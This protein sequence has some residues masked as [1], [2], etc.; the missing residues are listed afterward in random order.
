MGKLLFTRF[1]LGTVPILASAKMGLSPSVPT[2]APAKMG[3]SRSVCRLLAVAIVLL[4]VSPPS[5]RATIAS[6]GDV[7]PW[8][9]SS[10]GT[11]TTSYIGNT[12]SGT[13]TV[14]GGNLLSYYGYVGYGGSAS[15]VV[16]VS[17]STS[18]WTNGGTVTIGY[19]GSGT[20]DITSGGSLSDAAGYLGWQ[21]GSKGAVTVSGVGSTWTNTYSLLVGRYGSATLSISGGGSVSNADGYIG[22][23]SGAKGIV[24]VDGAG[25]TWTSRGSLTIGVD[26]NY[27]NNGGTLAITNAG[28]VSVVGE[29]R[30]GAGRASTGTITFGPGSGTLTTQSFFASPSQLAGTGTVNARGLVTDID[31][32]FD[33]THALK[34][35]VTLEQ[36][37]QSITVNLDMSVGTANGALGAGWKGAG[38]LTV[39][40]GMTV[41][42]AC[43]Y[44]GYGTAS[45]AS[46]TVA[47][48]G[49][50]WVNSGDLCVGHYGSG[51]LLITGGGTVS[52]VHG[53]VGDASGA[54]GVVTVSGVGSAWT[55]AAS[56]D[57]GGYGS[58]TLS[59]TSGGSVSSSA[60][61]IANLGG[62]MSAV[63][64]DGAGSK[65][66]N[67]GGLSLGVPSNF[68]Y[69]T[70]TLSIT[71][72]GAV[73]NTSGYV[74]GGN[75]TTAMVRISDP[76]STWTNTSNLCVGYGYV[77]KGTVSQADGTVSVGGALFLASESTSQGMYNLT[78][79]V[80]ILN[81]LSQGSGTAAF[82]FG[83]GTLRA[84]AAF[85]S[86]VP[87]NLTG[88]DGDA[89]VDTAGFA[90][91]LSGTLSGPGGLTKSGNGTLTLS[92]ANKYTGVTTVNSGT[93]T[94]SVSN[95]IYTGGVTLTGGVFNLNGHT[96]SVGAVMLAGGTIAGGTL[97][98]TVGFG[99]SSGAVSAVLA[100]SVG[101]AKSGSGT[102]ILSAANTYTGTTSVGSG[103]LVFQGTA[104]INAALSKTVSNVSAGMLVFD[105]S[106]NTASGPSIAGQINSIL[107][108]SYNGGTNSW[109]SGRI[110]STLANT[111]STDGYALGWT[112]NTTT[113]AVTVKVVLYGDADLDG[114]V[115]IYDLGKI[116]ANYNQSGVWA[117]GDFNYDGTVNIYDLGKILANYNKSISLSGVSINAADYAGLDGQGLAALQAA[118][119]NVVPEP[120][121]LALLAAGA[122]G[123]GALMRRRRT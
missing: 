14:N 9:A 3:L 57:V 21:S 20:L 91:T 71:N 11:G 87:M 24:A 7:N 41:N 62:F 66:T 81:G 98:S 100:G 75:S 65:W 107:T 30:V 28:S 90:V 40:D 96:D 18:K 16:A 108:A 32:R 10:W 80:L 72:G 69:G 6:S 115:N 86:S 113:S 116:L 37:G 117:T 101:L 67:S 42:S 64:V 119:V 99:V 56:L 39:Q 105:Y 23:Y 27:Y 29:T 47:G 54:K 38:S 88:T 73:S 59:I 83:G 25:S 33:S 118:G 52:N 74:A 111:H 89:N 95:A 8:P 22:S 31:L 106:G 79:G 60:G 76:G 58:G 12:A 51:A 122:V 4:A 19:F 92:A 17:G 97:T 103:T 78:G 70:A 123:L 2:F 110:Y 48:T 85:S 109:A 36:S 77:D 68:C 55:N 49:S 5:A 121:T 15:G 94:E 84:G 53:I 43:G 63:S 61:Y 114:T 93:L 34:R 26:D 44:L 35:T 102:V 104:S 82:N 120:G 112:N 46:A 45:T 13:V 1:R 50:A